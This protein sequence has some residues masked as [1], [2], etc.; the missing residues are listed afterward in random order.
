M[1]VDNGSLRYFLSRSRLCFQGTAVSIL[2][3]VGN[4]GRLVAPIAGS[5]SYVDIG[6]RY[7]YICIC[8]L[9]LTGLLCYLSLYKRMVPPAVSIETETADELILKERTEGESQS[10]QVLYASS[11]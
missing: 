11:V 10:G 7:T 1:P 2:S 4:T 5:A 8:S 3:A 6:P 9:V